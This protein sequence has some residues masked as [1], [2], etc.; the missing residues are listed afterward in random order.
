MHA[1]GERKKI[2]DGVREEL[3][4]RFKVLGC[5]FHD[6]VYRKRLITVDGVIENYPLM[7][8]DVIYKSGG[9]EWGGKGQVGNVMSGA[10]VPEF[11]WIS[12]QGIE[13]NWILNYN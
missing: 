1:P 7:R 11:S 13:M 2:I 8:L 3:S 4:K 12:Q 10:A 6:F 9:K 5:K